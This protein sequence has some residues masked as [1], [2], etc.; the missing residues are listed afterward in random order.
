MYPRGTHVS[1]CK[2]VP[3]T[4]LYNQLGRSAIGIEIEE[5]QSTRPRGREHQTTLLRL[6]HYGFN[7]RPRAGRGSEMGIMGFDAISFQ[8]TPLRERR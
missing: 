3:G 4:A 5:F 8:S 7:P 1:I 6:R 2:K